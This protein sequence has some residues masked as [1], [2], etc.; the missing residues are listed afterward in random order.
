[1]IS[2]QLIFQA[3]E[4]V[5]D[6]TIAHCFEKRYKDKDVI[7]IDINKTIHQYFKYNFPV[8]YK[9]MKFVIPN[10]P[11]QL[12]LAMDIDNKISAFICFFDEK[13][14][15][16]VSF[17]DILETNEEENTIQYTK[18]FKQYLEDGTMPRFVRFFNMNHP[19]NE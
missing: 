5:F 7:Y 9:R 16:C 17:L 2:T 19:N 4:L 15:W 10:S 11:V 3:L 13:E 6:G 1:M 12:G 8:V 14:K 18:E